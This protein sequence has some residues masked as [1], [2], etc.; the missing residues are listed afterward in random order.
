M[1]GD[2]YIPDTNNC[3]NAGLTSNLSDLFYIQTLYFPSDSKS[4]YLDQS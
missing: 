3:Y 2:E 4:N 1:A